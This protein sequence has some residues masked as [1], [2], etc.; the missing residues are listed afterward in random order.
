MDT[1]PGGLAWS[2]ASVVPKSWNAAVWGSELARQ[3]LA[4]MASYTV[5]RTVT[6][7]TTLA[8]G[9]YNLILFVDTYNRVVETDETNNRVVVSFTV[10]P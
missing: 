8:P 1:R 10:I 2:K 3:S 9:S 4:P 7:P 5:S 6:L